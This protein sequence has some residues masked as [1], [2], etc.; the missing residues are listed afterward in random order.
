MN[1]NF[2]AKGPR[3]I[4]SSWLHC[5]SQRVKY[6]PDV[7]TS[8]YT[9][10]LSLPQSWSWVLLTWAAYFILI[11]GSMRPDSL[12]WHTDSVQLDA[13]HD[14]RA[15][16]KG[17]LIYFLTSRGPTLSPVALLCFTWAPSH[18]GNVPD[19]QHLIIKQSR[20]EQFEMVNKC[21]AE[22]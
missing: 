4:I 11:E 7:H 17:N 12:S 19:L 10:H 22:N 1:H 20:S 6:F 3:Q 13:Q 5:S 16:L 2:A 21:N 14:T 8:H 15:K 18:S 9:Y